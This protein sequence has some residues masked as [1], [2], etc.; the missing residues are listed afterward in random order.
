M[1]VEIILKDGTYLETIKEIEEHFNVSLY[2]Y[3]DKHYKNLN[4]M[5]CTCQ[6]DLDKFMNEEP[7]R[8]QFEYDYVEYWE[9]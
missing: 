7:R 9:K 8:S 6:I 5:A 3:K 1:C 2:K 4:R